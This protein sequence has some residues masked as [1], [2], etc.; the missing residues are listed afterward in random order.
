MRENVEYE[1]CDTSRG[2]A[3]RRQL[4]PSSPTPALNAHRWHRSRPARIQPPHPGQRTSWW[5]CA[6]L[7]CVQMYTT[8]DVD[9][10]IGTRIPP[11]SM[12][13][14]RSRT[15][16]AS[17]LP[18]PTHAGAPPGTPAASARSTFVPTEHEAHA[19]ASRAL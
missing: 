16:S 7:H 1:V 9:D 14:G 6:F 19:G 10:L 11:D 17:D 8:S 15:W 12:R 13:A 18:Q 3:G 5:R 4:A 2:L